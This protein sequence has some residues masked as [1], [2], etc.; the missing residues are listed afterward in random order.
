[1]LATVSGVASRRGMNHKVTIKWFR[2]LE[3]DYMV[4]RFGVVF[5][6]EHRHVLYGLVDVLNVMG[7]SSEIQV[8]NKK[9]KKHDRFTVRIGQ[10]IDMYV[11]DARDYWRYLEQCLSFER[12]WLS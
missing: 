1:M 6:G 5:Q 10:E 12:A 11:E 7:D 4:E 8:Y 3:P 2:T 9:T